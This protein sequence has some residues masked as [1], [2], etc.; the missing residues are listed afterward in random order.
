MTGSYKQ[1]QKL[2]VIND[3]I[4]ADKQKQ[5]PTVIMPSNSI[6]KLLSALKVF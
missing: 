2:T 3:T 5:K 1:Q 4:P 6:T